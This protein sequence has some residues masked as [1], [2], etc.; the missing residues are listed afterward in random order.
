M[1]TINTITTK[2][3]VIRKSLIGKNQIITFTNNKQVKCTYNHDLVYNALKDR[4]NSMPCFVKYSSYTNSNNLP[5]FVR[6]L[7]K[8]V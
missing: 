8:L 4:F 2:R 6:N 5:V 3:F 7:D 1:K